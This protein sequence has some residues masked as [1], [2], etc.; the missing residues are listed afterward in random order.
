MAKHRNRL[1]EMLEE[2]TL[3]AFTLARDLMGYM[4]DD[5]VKDFAEK[6]DIEL[7][8]DEDDSPSYLYDDED[9][10]REAFAEFWAE[11]CREVPAWATDKPAKRQAFS[12]FV[13]DLQRVDDISEELAD[14]VTL[15]D[16]N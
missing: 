15:A 11:R 7:F 1:F 10:V 5:D 9:E 6:N 3:D 12:Y 14:S 8:P 4:S 13:D 2:G 16:D